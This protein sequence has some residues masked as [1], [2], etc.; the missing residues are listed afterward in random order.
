MIAVAGEFNPND[1]ALGNAT[2]PEKVAAKIEEARLA[3]PSKLS[4]RGFLDPLLGRVV[5]I[6]VQTPSDEQV[7]LD[8]AAD[9]VGA[10]TEAWRLYGDL[11]K[12]GSI[13]GWNLFG[14]DMEFM[15]MRSLILGVA[16]PSWAMSVLPSGIITYNAHFADLMIDVTGSPRKYLKLDLF[17][18]AIGLPGKNG[19]GKEF[20][21]LWTSGN[22]DDRAKA[23][24]YLA[25]DLTQTA[26]V[27]RHL[28]K[29]A[30][31]G[32]PIDSTEDVPYAA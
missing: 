6:G 26:G 2:D 17:A 21:G 12:H 18:R 19:N 27:G 23:A 24:D 13:A 32:R 1:V 5:A 8:A 28:S 9:E 22:P 15:R 4:D 25:N 14:F 10:L 31:M 29:A 16:V 3:Y 30:R 7:I 11:R 20:A